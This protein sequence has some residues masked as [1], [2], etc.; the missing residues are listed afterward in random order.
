MQLVNL[1]KTSSFNTSCKHCQATEL[2]ENGLDHRSRILNYCGNVVQSQVIRHVRGHFESI[3]KQI[4]LFSRQLKRFLH[5]MRWSQV[6]DG[7][8]FQ[9]F[10][11]HSPGEAGILQDGFQHF[12]S[13]TDLWAA[14]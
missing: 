1:R 5:T 9:T 3:F 12:L 13:L 8:T 4:P 11:S 14:S 10:C 2:P 6:P 7:K